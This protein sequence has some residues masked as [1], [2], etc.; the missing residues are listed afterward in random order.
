MY[1]GSGCE[2]LPS[3]VLLSGSSIYIAASKRG[4]DR[5]SDWREDGFLRICTCDVD[6]LFCNSLYAL[7]FDWPVG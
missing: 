5:L 2:C 4:F 3:S 1:V 6:S 7:Q